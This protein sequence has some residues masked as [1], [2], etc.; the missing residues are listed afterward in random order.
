MRQVFQQSY[1]GR[2]NERLAILQE[3]AVQ[4]ESTEKSHQLFKT[5]ILP[6]A[7]LAFQSAQA[8]Y[9]TGKDD[10]LSLIDAARSLKEAQFGALEAF[11]NYH[12]AITHLKWAIGEDV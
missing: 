7:R 11:V 12:K 8:A 4:M 6:S 10:F 9:Q 3:A 5:K 2:K 1:L